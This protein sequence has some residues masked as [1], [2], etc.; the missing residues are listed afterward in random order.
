M[1]KLLALLALLL[2]PSCATATRHLESPLMHYDKDTKYAIENRD[3]GFDIEVYYS[4]YQFIPESEVVVAACKS[5]LNYL[6]NNHARSNN[7]NIVP[8]NE[9]NI[10]IS[11]GRNGLIGI[12][13]CTAGAAVYWDD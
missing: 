6:A 8:I 9:Q 3:D 13:S 4:R 1:K 2:A 5:N 12:T 7:K 11:T 10:R